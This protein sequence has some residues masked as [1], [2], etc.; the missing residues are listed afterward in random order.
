MEFGG[1][2]TSLKPGLH[3][4]R[5]GSHTVVWFDPAV[6]D[7]SER[8][9]LGLQ[10]EEVLTGSPQA[11]LELYR[12]WQAAQAVIVEQA[13]KPLFNIERATEATLADSKSVELVRIE[14]Q[15]TRP[16]GRVFGKLV[17]ALLQQAQLPVRVDDL[18][19]IAEVEAR[20]LGSA[21][22]DIEPAVQ[23]ALTA[24][25]HPLLAGITT[26]TRLH[27]E[28]PVVLRQGEKLIEGVIDLAFLANQS[29][30]IV[31]FKTGPADKKRNRG[32]LELYRQALELATGF[33]V[34]AVLFEI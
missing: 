33:P 6:L 4:P 5:R 9:A 2:D 20:I 18:Q 30:T 17:H 16:A 8:R 24:L 27:R 29:W 25:Q 26:A 7:L 14:R 12:D 13:A 31:D 15:G 3:Y 1:D 22:S 34:R 23:T 21:G 11:G 32:Q 19:A 10:Y 28:F